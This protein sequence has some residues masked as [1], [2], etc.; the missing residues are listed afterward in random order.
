MY[1]Q[2]TNIINKHDYIGSYFWEKS[3][4]DPLYQQNVYALFY[5]RLWLYNS[6]LDSGAS[7]LS[8]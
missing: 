8:I 2:Q 1:N 3:F 6:F 4:Q 7:I 5:I